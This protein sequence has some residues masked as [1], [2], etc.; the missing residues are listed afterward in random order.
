MRSVGAIAGN[1]PSP[2]S[3]S[4]ANDGA[5][6]AVLLPEEV[7][8]TNMFNIRIEFR[9]RDTNVIRSARRLPKRCT[10]VLSLRYRPAD[11]NLRIEGASRCVG[12]PVNR[13]HRSSCRWS[14]RILG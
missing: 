8:E 5:W 6:I 11:D 7:F 13:R 2:G 9:H 1:A 12:N 3:R 14:N 4:E 10:L